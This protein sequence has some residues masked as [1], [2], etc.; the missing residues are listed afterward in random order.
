MWKIQRSMKKLLQRLHHLECCSSEKETV[1][2]LV[3]TAI[4][5]KSP[6]QKT[7]EG[8]EQYTPY[9]PLEK[10]NALEEKKML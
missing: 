9:Q 7:D 1:D 5:K 8:N 3:D 6:V 4:L 2:K 10:T